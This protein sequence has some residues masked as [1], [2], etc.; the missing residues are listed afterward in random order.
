MSDEQSVELGF[1]ISSARADATNLIFKNVLANIPSGVMSL[2]SDG[3]VTSFN[4][5]AS[6]IVGLAGEAVVERTWA[7]VFSE[8][9]GADDFA[10]VI[11]DAVYDTLV[12]HQ[13]VVEATFFGR[14]RSL[15]VATSYL[16]EE[17]NGETV[18]IGVV[19]VFNDISEIRELREKE[20]R[21]AK[22]LQAKH[23][24][25]RDAYLSLEER[26]RELSTTSRRRNALRLGAS[27]VVLALIS[28]VGLYM[29]N[30]GP[31]TPGTTA[32]AGSAQAVQGAFATLVVA[33]RPISSTITVVGQL[34]PRQEIEVT[35]PIEGTVAEVHF[36]YGEKV[37]SGQRLVDLDV[38]EIQIEFREAQVAQIKARDQLDELEDWSNHVEVS[39]ARRVVSRA[40]IDLEARK[41]RLS[42]TAF[43]LEQGLI[44][45]SEHEAAERE[46]SNQLLDL[47]SAEEDLEVVLERGGAEAGV[48]RLELENARAR[49]QSLE[50]VIRNATVFAP[51]TGVIMHPERTDGGPQGS[52][53]GQHLAKGASV[54]QGEH[55]VSIGDLD[56]FTVVGMVDEVDV[57]TIRRGHPAKIVGAAFPGIELQG[58]IVRVSS[59]ASQSDER[60]GLPSFEVAAAVKRLTAEQRRQLRLGMSAI[61]EVVVYER[62]DALLVPID[63]VEFVGD[64][65]RLRIKDK[66]LDAV[67]YADVVTGATNLDSVEIIE[68]IRGGDEI[69]IPKR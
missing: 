33:P 42:Q 41:N 57:A 46:Y 19:V 22:E 9:E 63:A 44:P 65:P 49:L 26:N 30:Y 37:A 36:Q 12:G 18:T 25:L 39:R 4:A 62:K 58:E 51:V 28:G 21:L 47:Q 45:A 8:M 11:F 24:E 55:L 64:Q 14:R 69:V 50:E 17:R 3:V 59:Q 66:A 48:A 16:K 20:L 67:R 53:R 23:A 52:E 5:A 56:G 13:R 54:K 6:E 10:D 61:L 2:D 32:G 35:S 34:A 60:N 15:S 27:V 7:E 31:E 40:R 43:L 38:T 1:R 29:W 68:G